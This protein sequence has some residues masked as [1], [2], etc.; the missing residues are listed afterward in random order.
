M[1]RLSFLVIALILTVLAGCASAP[2]PVKETPIFYPDPPDP[3]RVQYLKSF[4][5]AKDFVPR[6]SVFS[7]FVTGRRD[8]N[9]RLDKPYGVAGYRGKI[10]VCDTNSTVMVFDLEKRTFGPLLGAQGIGKLIQPLNISIDKDGNKF[11][12][13]PIRSQVVMY[14]KNDMYVKAF[15]PVEGWQ[16]TDAAR[17]EDLLYVVDLKG[18]EIKIFDINTGAL[19]NSIGK[20][21]LALPTNIVFDK[22]GYMYVSDTSR[23]QILKLDRDGNVRKIIG[24]LGKL[25]GSFVRPRGLALDHDD[26]LYV[27]DGGFNN[28]QMFNP[29]GQLL[30][31]FGQGGIDRGDLYLA[32]KVAIDYD[33]VKYFQQYADPNF[34]IQYLIIVTSQFGNQLVNVYGFGTEKGKVYKTDEEL[35]KQLKEEIEKREKLQKEQEEK[36]EKEKAEKEKAEK[37]KA[38]GQTTDN[39]EK[40]EKAAGGTEKRD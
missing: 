33:D 38:A 15:G 21:Q 19:R 10:Y 20:G 2:P 34:Q 11:V 32:A 31:F 4:V 24:S 30:L 28:V 18:P 1:N 22:E 13:D 7:A 27:V 8:Q 35:L 37:E 23:F 26:R 36:A 12:S 40:P 25:P 6:Q 16:P 14:D 39:P 3:P 17:Y 9:L 5:G 29:D